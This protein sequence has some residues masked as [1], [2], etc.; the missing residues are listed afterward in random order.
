M[1][2]KKE[3]MNLTKLHLLEYN[4]IFDFVIRSYI[5]EFGERK[6]KIILDK[7]M[8]SNKVSGLISTAKYKR[9]P[10]GANDYLYCLNEIPYFIFS[11]GQTQ[12]V[13]ALIALQRWNEEVNSQQFILFEED[14]RSRALSILEISKVTFF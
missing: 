2:F 3:K 4:E 8:T 14:L 10:P 7:V 13:A 6:F 1:S 12:A 11:R 9:I 5:R